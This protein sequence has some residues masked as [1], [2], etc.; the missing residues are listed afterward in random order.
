M[1]GNTGEIKIRSERELYQCINHQAGTTKVSTR[2]ILI[3]MHNIFRLLKG[4]P[5]YSSEPFR[6]KVI[7][8]MLLLLFDRGL[9][10]NHRLMWKTYST[11]PLLRNTELRKSA[12]DF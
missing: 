10:V 5:D 12:S 2:I 9:S 4:V 7:G 8:F 1:R 11:R 6:E 3:Q